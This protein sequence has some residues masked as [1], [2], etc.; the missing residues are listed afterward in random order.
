MGLT[1]NLPN[2][3]CLHVCS[4]AAC[5][6]ESL[7]SCLTLCNTIDGSPPGPSVPG[8]LQI[9]TMEW[10]AISSSNA[11]MHA[12]LLQLCPT[13]CDLMDRSPLGS[14]VHGISQGRILE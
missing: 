5:A 12:K 4:A 11:C 8:I 13:L 3:M 6:A 7:Q 14:S 9:G 10:I 1:N 2:V